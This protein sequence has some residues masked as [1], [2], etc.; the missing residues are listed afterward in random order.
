MIPPSP[1]PTETIE[2][3]LRFQME[4]EP[5]AFVAACRQGCGGRARCGG[6]CV[7]CL[8]AELDLRKAKVSPWPELAT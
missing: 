2:T 6:V 8:R 3:A 7:D 1:W 4:R 5:A